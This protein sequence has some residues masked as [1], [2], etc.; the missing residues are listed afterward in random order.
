M[1]AI[2]RRAGRRDLPSIQ[3]LWEGL[4]A[5]GASADPRL[6]PSANAGKLVAEHREVLLGDPRTAFFVAEE[7]AEIVGF[8]HA[9]IEPNDP[10]LRPERYGTV[11]DLFVAD[12]SR[13]KGVGSQL[14]ARSEE[15][16][17]SHN[18]SQIRIAVPVGHGTAGPFLLRRG[19]QALSTLYTIELDPED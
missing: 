12:S 11:V 6:R 7:Q 13:G 15:W 1:G 17:R 3:A 14:L 10:V 8:L 18:L 16:F 4:R 19:A 9:Q 2:V 5:L